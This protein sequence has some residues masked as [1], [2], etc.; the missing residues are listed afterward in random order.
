MKCNR[1]PDLSFIGKAVIGKL[2]WES[3]IWD[4]EDN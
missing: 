3:N 4:Q 2:L 1:G